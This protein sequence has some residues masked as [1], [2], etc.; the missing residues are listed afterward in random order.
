M[1]TKEQ[2]IQVCAE[3]V[4]TLGKFEWFRD[5]VVWEQHPVTLGPVLELKVNY[6]PRLND[7]DIKGFALRIGFPEVRY[8]EVDHNGNPIQ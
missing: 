6:V 8:T 1:L 2:Q 7:K 3:V 4:K 5:V